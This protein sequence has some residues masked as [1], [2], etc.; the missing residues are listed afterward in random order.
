MLHELPHDPITDESRKYPPIIMTL[1]LIKISLALTQVGYLH[2][3][4]MTFRA[5]I[6]SMRQIDD[7]KTLC[8]NDQIACL[9]GDR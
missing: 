8:E 5:I 2:Q 9:K 4:N 1:S 3:Y 6:S 7:F